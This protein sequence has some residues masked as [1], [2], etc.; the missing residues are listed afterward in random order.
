LVLTRNLIELYYLWNSNHISE[1]SNKLAE[2]DLIIGN[3]DNQKIKEK[4]NNF[5]S[6]GKS[7]SETDNYVWN[8]LN[9]IY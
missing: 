1:F 9:L 4:W 8:L 7:C 3:L 6:C 2:V 5:V